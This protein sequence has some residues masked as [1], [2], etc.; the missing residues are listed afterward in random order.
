VFNM[1]SLALWLDAAQ[2]VK[3]GIAPVDAHKRVEELR[4]QSAKAL[5][6]LRVR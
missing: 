1:E 2:N 5:S 4:G 6:A 3:R